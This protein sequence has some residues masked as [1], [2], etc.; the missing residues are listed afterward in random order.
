MSMS[1]DNTTSNLAEPLK[2]QV[3]DGNKND[4]VQFLYG[5]LIIG[6]CIGVVSLLVLIGKIYENIITLRA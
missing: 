5:P 3:K 2:P 6:V 1:S 4:T